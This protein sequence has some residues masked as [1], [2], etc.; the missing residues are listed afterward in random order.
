MWEEF[1]RPH[2]ARLL[3]ADFFTVETCGVLLLS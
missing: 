1:V 2:A 3:A